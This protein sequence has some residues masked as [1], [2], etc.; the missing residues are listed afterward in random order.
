[1]LVS[2][3]CFAPTSVGAAVERLLTRLTHWS[4]EESGKAGDI[5]Y[6][7]WSNVPRSRS[8]SIR[9]RRAIR[10]SGV[11]P[12]GSLVSPGIWIGIGEVPSTLTNI[13]LVLPAGRSTMQSAPF[14]FLPLRRLVIRNCE[15]FANN[16]FATSEKILLPVNQ[17][18]CEMHVHGTGMRMSVGK[19]FLKQ[20]L[21]LS[22]LT[23][24]NVG[25]AVDIDR[26]FLWRCTNLRWFDT[27]LIT[28]IKT[29][30]KDACDGTAL[31]DDLLAVGLL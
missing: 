12:Q 24:A 26:G 20:C 6:I 15:S 19:W 8:E 13:D 7:L 2:R 5:D 25:G 28:H 14:A 21:A 16:F 1:M 29:L 23:F 11:P 4:Q 22:V 3:F 27:Q 31:R 30:P 17:T 10:L 9:G 18:L